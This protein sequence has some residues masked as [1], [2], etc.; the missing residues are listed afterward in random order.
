MITTLQHRN[1]EVGVS[2]LQGDR[3]RELV[4]PFRAIVARC[5][6]EVVE[7]CDGAERGGRGGLA[8]FG[9]A[10]VVL[11]AAADADVPEGE[12]GGGRREGAV[13]HGDVGEGVAEGVDAAEEGVGDGDVGHVV[14]DGGG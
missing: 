9:G 5:A 6:G 7:L 10:G 2:I 13:V 4:H 3:I 11:R 1:S 14:A 8:F 12:A